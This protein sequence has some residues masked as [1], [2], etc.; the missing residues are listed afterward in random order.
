ML[1]IVHYK[2]LYLKRSEK[3]TQGGWGMSQQKVVFK[4]MAVALGITTIILLVGLVAVVVGYTS[5]IS[6]RDSQIADLQSI[7]D[8]EKQ[9]VVVDNYAVNQG[10]NT[11]STVIHRS[12]SYSG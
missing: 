4:N 2:I 3:I 10:A 1:A 11:F 5:T 9:E 6:N 12:Y 8:L 7:L